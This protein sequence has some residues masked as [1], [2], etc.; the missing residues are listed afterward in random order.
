MIGANEST[1]LWWP[2][3]IYIVYMVNYVFVKWNVKM[4][5]RLGLAQKQSPM[6]GLNLDSEVTALPK[7]YNH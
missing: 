4:A 2:P 5:K 1:E 6:N 3:S 7:C